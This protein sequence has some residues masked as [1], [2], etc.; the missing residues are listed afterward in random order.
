MQADD[1]SM[2]IDSYIALGEVFV[3]RR[4]GRI[5]GHIQLL[6]RGADWEIKS[7]AVIEAERARG[8]GGALVGD[9]LHR[10]FSEGAGRVRVGTATAD[11]A[12]LRFYQRLG[13]RAHRV[14]RDA[15]TPSRGY[16]NLK[17][18]GIPIRDRVWL[19]LDGRDYRSMH[20]STPTCRSARASRTPTT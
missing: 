7:I 5:V 15:F 1:S 4:A 18:D 12:N 2:A 14:E 8:V 9:A 13:F 16:R 3:A 17:V 6:A 11:L 20:D 19:T 10:A